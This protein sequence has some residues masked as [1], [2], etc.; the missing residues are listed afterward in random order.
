MWHYFSPSRILQTFEEATEK[1]RRGNLF[2]S[3]NKKILN[4]KLKL[5]FEPTYNPILLS[6]HSI[7]R[8]SA[9]ALLRHLLCGPVLANGRE[10]WDWNVTT[11]QGGWG[12]FV[13]DEE[14]WV[15]QSETEPCLGDC[16]ANCFV[17]HES[18]PGAVLET[19][20]QNS[21]MY[22]LVDHRNCVEL[23]V[24]KYVLKIYFSRRGKFL[25]IDIFV[26]PNFRV[27]LMFLIM[28]ISS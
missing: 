28:V 21:T 3:E 2:S 16:A 11:R 25:F 19:T 12:W 7:S 10:T 17:G 22:W 27:K 14:Q 18:T 5:D 13:E 26:K 15:S 24:G 23:A 6:K 1:H 20:P 4:V 8:Q 9:I